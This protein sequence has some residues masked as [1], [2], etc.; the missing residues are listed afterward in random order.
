MKTAVGKFIVR[1]DQRIFY[2]K[3]FGH[4]LG[5]PAEPKLYYVTFE[6]AQ[7]SVLHSYKSEITEWLKQ[8]LLLDHVFS[9]SKSLIHNHRMY[10]LSHLTANTSLS[11][12]T[13][14]HQIFFLF[15]SSSNRP[16]HIM[17]ILF[18]LYYATLLT[19]L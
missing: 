10:V 9:L 14:A 7:G 1:P 13:A 8:M 3:I 18:S 6:H 5:Q 12:R 17:L 19:Q 16:A 15:W 2:A 11:I 4:K